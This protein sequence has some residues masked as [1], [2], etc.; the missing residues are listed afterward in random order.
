MAMSEL[1]VGDRGRVG[2]TSP[3]WGALP[4]VTTQVEVHA[5]PFASFRDVMRFIERMSVVQGVRDVRVD[6]WVAGRAVLIVRHHDRMPLL[7]ALRTLEADGSLTVG[8]RRPHGI[9][10]EV[11]QTA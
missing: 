8:M 4:P 2:R 3:S 1:R 5:G 7:T 9:Q 6:R 10:V 11:K